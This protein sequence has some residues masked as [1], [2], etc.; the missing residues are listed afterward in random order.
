MVM[1]GALIDGYTYHVSSSAL[2]F[3]RCNLIQSMEWKFACDWSHIVPTPA[4]ALT[5]ATAF[6]EAFDNKQQPGKQV[7]LFNSPRETSVQLVVVLE[8]N[9]HCYLTSWCQSNEVITQVSPRFAHINACT[10]H[11]VKWVVRIAVDDM[12]LKM[13]MGRANNSWNGGKC[14]FLHSITNNIHVKRFEKASCFH[15]ILLHPL[16][17]FFWRPMYEVSCLRNQSPLHRIE[18]QPPAEKQIQEHAPL[19]SLDVPTECGLSYFW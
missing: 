6:N 19:E 12:L 7:R 5:S 15:G 2:P 11:S 13:S 1:Y 3:Q 8:V 17:L 9:K 10:S 16:I 4:P 18:S 14:T